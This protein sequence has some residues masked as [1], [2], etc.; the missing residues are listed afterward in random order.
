MSRRQ[1][2]YGKVETATVR[3]ICLVSDV[4]RPLC[5]LINDGYRHSAHEGVR[6]L[7]SLEFLIELSCINTSKL[8]SSPVPIRLNDLC[9]S[10]LTQRRYGTNALLS[11]KSLPERP[12]K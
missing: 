6:A 8:Q 5:H 10:P 1:R 3:Q 7:I 9:E 12:D 11:I 4:I 2:Q